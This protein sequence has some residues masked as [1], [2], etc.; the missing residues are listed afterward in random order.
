MVPMYVL[1]FCHVSLSLFL[2]QHNIMWSSRLMF[3]CFM[4]VNILLVPWG[5][6]HERIIYTPICSHFTRT[7]IL[8]VYQAI[9][10]NFASLPSS[11]VVLL[12][13]ISIDSIFWYCNCTSL[14]KIKHDARQLNTTVSECMRWCSTG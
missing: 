12:I 10:F 3:R 5:R 4:F 2:Y 6:I 14:R 13:I 9:K 1:W 8:H 7:N 11:F